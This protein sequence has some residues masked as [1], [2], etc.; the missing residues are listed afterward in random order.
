MASEAWTGARLRKTSV[1]PHQTITSRSQL[2]FFLNSLMS[3]ITCAARS[4]LFLPVLKWVAVSF[5]T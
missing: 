4:A 3:S 2:F 5:F 1:E